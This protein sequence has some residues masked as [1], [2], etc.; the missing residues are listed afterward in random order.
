MKQTVLYVSTASSIPRYRHGRVLF[1]PINTTWSSYTSVKSDIL[2]R[3]MVD[4]LWFNDLPTVVYPEFG[5]F[6]MRKWFTAINSIQEQ[7]MPGMVLFV[8]NTMSRTHRGNCSVPLLL[9]RKSHPQFHQQ[10]KLPC[11]R[12]HLWPEL[13]STHQPCIQASS[14]TSQKFGFYPMDSYFGT[15][16]NQKPNTILC[17]GM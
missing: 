7:L 14:E 12:H 17:W 4:P 9:V 6:V 16:Q 11:S 2:W 5:S 1:S 13:C 15:E 3:I 10:W 8:G